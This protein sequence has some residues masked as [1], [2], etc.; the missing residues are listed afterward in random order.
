[1]PRSTEQI[2]K[3][4]NSRMNQKY[5]CINAFTIWF[6]NS[7]R[8]NEIITEEEYQKLSYKNRA[9]FI[10]C[11]APDPQPVTKV[12]PLHSQALNNNRNENY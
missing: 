11:D 7:Y 5:R 8:V 10:P 3:D 6:L 9:N 1:M 2:I 12:V 4:I